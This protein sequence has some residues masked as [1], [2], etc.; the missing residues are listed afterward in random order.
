MQA[1]YS[2]KHKTHG[3]LFLA[4]TDTAGNLL[5]ISAARPGR[6]SWITTARRNNLVQ[7]LCEAGL[8]ALA[9]LGMVG[10]DDDLEGSVVIAGR[11]ATCTKPLTTAEKQVNR[12]I[13][14]ERA[15]V[16]HG[17]ADLKD[18]RILTKLRIN[19]A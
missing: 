2:G 7:K 6:S 11:K 3:L 16:E 15:P 1:V 5:W 19:P 9:D 4:L 14:S 12:L 13:S 17:F 10:L 18:W 8:G